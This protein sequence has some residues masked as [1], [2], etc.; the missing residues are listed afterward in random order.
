MVAKRPASSTYRLQLHAGFTFDD[1]AAVV[2]YLTLVG[3]WPLTEERLAGYMEKATREAKRHTSWTSP[4]PTYDRS[5][6]QFVSCAI[7]DPA[8]MADVASFVARILVPGRINALAQT[9]IKLTAPG[10]PDIYQGTD[11][12]SLDLVDPDN[13]RQVDFDVRRR[14]LAELEGLPAAEI[15]ARADSGLPKLWVIRQALALR[16]RRPEG[17]GA[18]GTYTPLNASGP[19]AS[20][21]VAFGRGHAVVTIAPR[22][23]VKAASDWR[24]TRVTLPRG[25]WQNVLTGDRYPAC[26]QLPELWRDFPVALLE[27]E[28]D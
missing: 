28:V 13:R 4:N 25:A 15:G 22:L 24:D 27:R 23:S 21:V 12:W 14:L 18:D 17:F 9:L 8:L 26:V 16:R 10:V 20:H 2:P 5:L 6:R 3:A 11:L 1:A 19:R 7:A